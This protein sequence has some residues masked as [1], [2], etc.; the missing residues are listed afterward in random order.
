[1]DHMV[2][3]RVARDTDKEMAVALMQGRV[4]TVAMDSKL[5]VTANPK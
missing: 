2:G 1:M 5:M 3:S 4:A